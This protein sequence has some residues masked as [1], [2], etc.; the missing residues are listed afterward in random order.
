MEPSEGEHK[1]SDGAVP[2]GAV[3]RRILL[4]EDQPVN[5]K[6]ARG[7]LEKMGHRVDVAENGREALAALEKNLYDAVLMDIRMPV[8]DGL[9]ATRRIRSA[10]SPV[11]NPGVPI[12]AMTAHVMEEDR[13]RCLAAGMDGYL[14]KPISAAALRV[15]LE[16]A[17]FS[18]VTEKEP[19]APE[20][21]DAVFDGASL[22]DRLGGDRALAASVVAMFIDSAKTERARLIRSLSAGDEKGARRHAHTLKGMAANVSARSVRTI[23]GEIEKKAAAGRSEP[24]DPLLNDFDAALAAFQTHPKVR[25]FVAETTGYGR[26]E[27]FH[28]Q[29]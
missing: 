18:P 11:L 22:L 10:D 16:E 7:V 5:Q 17:I 6:V 23:A 14:T 20:T 29:D 19:P 9:A 13:E 28:G 25:S 2:E 3:S 21:A 24:G 26:I 15:A 8:M 1:V 4:V 27:T 12:V